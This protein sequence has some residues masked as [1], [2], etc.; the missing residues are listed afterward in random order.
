MSDTDEPLPREP[1]VQTHAPALPGPT[2]PGEQR[3][4]DAAALI[5]LA[6]D[7]ATLARQVLNNIPGIL[8]T[9]LDSQMR[10]VS[11]RTGHPLTADRGTEY[12]LGRSVY[13]LLQPEEAEQISQEYS[14]ALQGE[15]RSF[16]FRQESW[17]GLTVF[18][19]TAGPLWSEHDG[20]VG[21]VIAASDITGQIDAEERRTR[22]FQRYLETFQ[23]TPLPMLL[24]TASGQVAELNGALLALVGR[25]RSAVLGASLLSLVDPRDHDRLDAVLPELL[26]GAMSTA[27]VELRLL[28]W[29][30]P[31]VSCQ[32]H[33]MGRSPRDD[34]TLATVQIVDQTQQRRHD[35]ELEYMAGHDRL[36]GLV[37]RRVF[38]ERAA[39]HLAN[40]ERYGYEGG[41]VVVSVDHFKQINQ[42]KG[43]A[44]GDQV[45]VELTG[46]LK[47]GK[48]QTTVV[49]RL[50]G[51]EFALL[52]TQGDVQATMRSAEGLLAAAHDHARAA[53]VAG[54]VAFTLSIGL[55][56]ITAESPTPGDLLALAEHALHGAK[57]GGRDRIAMPEILAAGR[58]ERRSQTAIG[59]LRRALR[60]ERFELHAQ[61]IMRLS[62]DHISQYELLI[63]LRDE[64][65]E[66]VPPA[67]F[68]PLAEHYGLVGE[69]DAWVARTA[70]Q[71]LATLDRDV[72]FQLNISGHSMGHP[73]LLDGITDGLRAH[74][75]AAKRLVFELTETAAIEN[76]PQ[77]LAFAERLKELGCE[78][79]LD[80]FGAGFA[81]LQYLKHLPFSY[82]KID[83]EFVQNVATNE[84]DQLMVG[85]MLAITQGMHLRTVAEFVGDSACLEQL[86]SMGVDFAQGFFLGRPRPL[87]KV[88][89]ELAPVGAGRRNGHGN[90][91]GNGHGNGQSN[92]RAA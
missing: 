73:A 24:L 7:E 74:S 54:G 63:R 18:D 64:N 76:V 31:P 50:G 28:A 61:P 29:D 22:M 55:A 66:L 39:S 69:I 86:R 34:D 82:V 57:R 2:G 67:G 23:L 15:V 45:L 17:R 71:A 88:L 26:T 60:D 20:I 30:E 91:N 80:D 43:R 10:V 58:A 87:A 83:G 78:L 11:M 4:T 90:G 92:G 25:E 49:A 59:R 36:T 48:D 81:S 56:P 62:D 65:D 40:C 19:V 9:V 37:N 12:Y 27:T 3:A 13:E 44:A 75:V 52:I 77:A 5:R 84:T 1:V 68:L 14:A 32:V 70:V 33:I 16:T 51:D 85:G 42:A 72:I 35:A 8:V 53:R 46:L 79:A 6:S 47:R 38:E 89:R 21:V 41:V